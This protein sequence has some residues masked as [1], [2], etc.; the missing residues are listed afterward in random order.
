LQTR[1]NVKLIFYRAEAI[2]EENVK[3][4]SKLNAIST[5]SGCPEGITFRKGIH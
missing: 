3:I 1:S 4:F 2:E 5:R